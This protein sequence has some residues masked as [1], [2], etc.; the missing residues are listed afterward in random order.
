MEGFLPLPSEGYNISTARTSS[1]ADLP[2]S[3]ASLS[4][5]YSCFFRSFFLCSTLSHTSSFLGAYSLCMHHTSMFCVCP[6]HP[7]PSCI[8]FLRISL[9]SSY[10]HP[11]VL[12][13]W[14]A[15]S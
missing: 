1:M 4:S 2:L 6:P 14:R 15:I 8:S 10:V 5:L 7:F 11:S 12:S 13:L 9:F 3:S